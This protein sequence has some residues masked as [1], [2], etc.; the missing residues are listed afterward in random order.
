M[1]QEAL[2]L[3]REDLI[4]KAKVNYG[5]LNEAAAK[6]KLFLAK[7]RSGEADPETIQ[8]RIESLR[9]DYHRY[10]RRFDKISKKLQVINEKINH[11]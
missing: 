5:M 4:K 6:S 3:K 7:I 8:K 2:M 11:I 1:N 10:M 9:S